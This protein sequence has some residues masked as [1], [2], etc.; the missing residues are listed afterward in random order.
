MSTR[1]KI[2]SGNLKTAN[3]FLLLTLLAWAL[4]VPVPVAG[5]GNATNVTSLFITID[6][7]GNQTVDSA[8]F[9][10]GTTNLPASGEPLRLVIGTFNP[11]GT[12]SSF[13]SNVFIIPGESGINTWS[14][15][16]APSGWETT[17]GRRENY[18]IVPGEIIPGEYTVTVVSQDPG[19]TADVDQN[20]RISASSAPV[21][22]PVTIRSSPLSLGVPISG[23]AALVIM[24]VYRKKH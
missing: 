22:I 1:E 18:T 9:I 8:F 7:I 14:C 2:N 16:V 17:T 20:L 24:A 15:T 23:I 11:G 19:K 6:P 10:N 3:L 21:T 12:G 4:V 13:V 5:Q